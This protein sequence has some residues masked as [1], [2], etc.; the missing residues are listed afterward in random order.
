M[1][2]DRVR[3]IYLQKQRE[4]GRERARESERKKEIYRRKT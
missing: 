3:K 2:R 4:R 1:E